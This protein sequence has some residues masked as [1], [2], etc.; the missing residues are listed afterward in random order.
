MSRFRPDLD[1]FC[2]K[3]KRLLMEVK[4]HG[5]DGNELRDNLESWYTYTVIQIL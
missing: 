4:F 5:K 3:L 1:L 2:V